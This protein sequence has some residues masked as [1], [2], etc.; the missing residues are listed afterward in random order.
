MLASPILS[1]EEIRAATEA[2]AP[3]PSWLELAHSLNA[4]AKSGPSE[5]LGVLS[6]AFVYDLVDPSHDARRSAAGG[7]YATMWEAEGEAFPPR[8]T[9][10]DEDVRRLWRAARDAIDDSIVG[11]RIGD[12][13]Y[14][15]EGMRAHA[16]GRSG[17]RGLMTLARGTDWG[18]LD[19]SVCMARAL[20]VLAELNDKEALTEAGASAFALVDELLALE[21]PGPPFKV[22]RALIGLKAKDRPADFD[23][24]VDRVIE[25]FDGAAHA[26]EGALALAAEATSDPNRRKSLLR[27]RL[28]V[29]IDEAGTADGLAKVSLMQ[30]AI[31]LARQHGFTTEAQTLL[32]ELQE[33]PKEDLEFQA[34]DAS[35]DIPTEAIRAQVDLVVGS[36]A[37]DLFDALNRL[38]SFGPPGGSNADIDAEVEQQESDHPI[39]GLFGRQVIGPETSAPNFIA[40]DPESKKLLARGQQRTMHAA[41][42][43]DLLI[44]PMLDEAAKRHGR[45]THDE[46]TQHF[47]TALIGPDRAERLARALELFWDGHYDDAAHVIVP[48]LESTLRGV[49]RRCGI[50][51]AKPARPGVFAGIVSLNTVMSKLCELNPGTDWLDYLE[52]LLCDP[53]G[54]NLRNDVAHGIVP[55]VGRVNAALAIHAAC[56]LALLDEQPKS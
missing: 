17:A 6:L 3:R 14:V 47:S 9:E 45:P 34:V 31:E 21:H 15:A 10:V 28:Q 37:A 27:R 1:D 26:K 38:G 51:I 8:P 30:R 35:V 2:L 4:L 23:A 41:F 50:T 56:Y 42:Y 49:A 25:R 36:H 44:S 18:A 52:A 43:G 39:L 7:P 12:L 11:S 16:D 48:R 20:E 54:V 29:R 24:L 19:R 53:L 55:R 40:N 22:V 5:R 33:L 46:L 13:L 32:A